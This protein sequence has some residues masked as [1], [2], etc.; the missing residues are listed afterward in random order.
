MNVNKTLGAVVLT[1]LFSTVVVAQ[2]YQA[3]H[4]AYWRPSVDSDYH[5]A[6]VKITGDGYGG[7]GTV[8]KR[9]EDSEV[10]GYYIGWILT[11]SHVIRDKETLFNV[12]FIDGTITENGTVVV[13][14]DFNSNQFCDYG[15][16]RAIIPNNV[17]PMEIS[18]DE[19]PV[20]TDVE[21]C[22]YGRGSL[23]H[24]L[25]SY[26]GDKADGDGHIVWAFAVQGDSGGPIIHEGKIVGII[27][28]GT[29]VERF[30]GTARYV[31][32]PVYGTCVSRIKK[33]L[34]E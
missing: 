24:W 27:C 32:T 23:K 15:L 11:A 28:F 19:V 21:M 1:L 6:I 3:T 18:V 20:G 10:E 16:I 7:S 17:K 30:G 26:A 25:G 4:D 33:L 8:V 22:G 34:E 13:N 14:S 31:V 5:K 9:I 29:G 12:Y 2:S